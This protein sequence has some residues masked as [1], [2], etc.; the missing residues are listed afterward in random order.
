MYVIRGKQFKE[1]TKVI[2]CSQETKSTKAI[3]TRHVKETSGYGG[4]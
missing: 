3:D 4:Y 1:E 2:E